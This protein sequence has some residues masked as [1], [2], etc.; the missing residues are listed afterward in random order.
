MGTTIQK[1]VEQM[2]NIGNYF[3][4]NK[5]L[6]RIERYKKNKQLFKGNHFEVFEKYKNVLSSRS[7]RL[8]YVSSNLPSIIVKKSAD[9][10]FGEPITVNAGKKDDSA[11][12][13]AL[14]RIKNTN[15]LDITNYES[16]LGNGYRGDSYYK[17]R[18]GQEHEGL[19]PNEEY[20]VIIE[21]QNAEYVF[22]E[23]Y[24]NNA[25]KIK[26][27]HICIPQEVK[28]DDYI[29]NVES[30]Y[31]NQIVYHR[32]RMTVTATDAM[33]IPKQYR[34]YAPLDEPQVIETGIP[35]PLV[36][37]MPNYATDDSWEGIDDL[38]E[39]LPIFEEIN[40]RLSQIAE[41]LD[42]HADPML[43]VPAGTLVEDEQG[44]PVFRAGVDK[45]FE[46]MDKSEVT[47]QYIT[48]QGKISEG[49]EEIRLLI[50]HLLMN[51]ELP[52]VA[53]GS[54][55]A[56]TSGSSGLAIKWRLNSL[57]SKISR[58]RQYYDKALKR[59]FLIAQLIEHDRLGAKAGYEISPVHITFKDG[60]PE[61]EMEKT[62]ILTIQTGGAKLTSQ[63]R[64]IMEIHNCTEEQA[65]VILD[66][67]KKEEE[68]ATPKVQPSF[69]ND[70]EEFDPADEEETD[71]T[72][73]DE[74]VE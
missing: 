25:K 17:L 40:T 61:D 69:F 20:R 23:T 24:S 1:G 6:A 28:G 67:I 7:N 8:V 54:G 9:F 13:K 43:V 36:V 4:S 42:R 22:P 33:G 2:F 31:P 34:I 46:I 71:E 27:Y 64:A 49:F 56:G 62:N 15:D 68:A 47:P 32:Y 73:E 12:Q 19:I 66:Q 48:W 51:A 53:L 60:F 37:H 72:K 26:A 52:S 29:L 14:E 5:H 21:A 30:H 58:K 63:I 44:N 65:Q 41:I 55:E 57:L 39:H 18:W 59:V 3:P 74:E 16:A 35:F 10:L 11:E 50:D 70:D 45:V 38:T